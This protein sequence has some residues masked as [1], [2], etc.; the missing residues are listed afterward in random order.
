MA[1]IYLKSGE[2]VLR[3]NKKDER[4]RLKGCPSTPT[5]TSDK[6][7]YQ[8][9]TNRSTIEWIYSNFNRAEISPRVDDF[10]RA[11]MTAEIPDTPFPTDYE[12]NIIPPFNGPMENQRRVLDRAWMKDSFAIFHEMGCGKSLSAISL[13]AAYWMHGETQGALIVCPTAIKFNWVRQLEIHWPSNEYVDWYVLYPHNMRTCEEWIKEDTDACKILIAGVEALSQGNAWKMAEKFLNSTDSMMIIDESSRIKTPY[14]ID[15]KKGIVKKGIRTYRC[16]ELGKLAKRRIIM[17]G[18]QVTQ[19]IEDLYSQFE[20]LD[21]AI[22][23]SSNF[24]AFRNAY[25]VMGGAMGKQ[26][27]GYRDTQK[28][29]Q[30]LAPYT[31][32]CRLDEIADIPEAVQNELIVRL[33]DEQNSL[34]RQLKDELMAEFQGRT[35]TINTI[36]EYMLRAQ[37]VVGGFMPLKKE[38]AHLLRK[39]ESKYESLPLSTNPKLDAA[40]E[41]VQELPPGGKAIIWARFIPEIKRIKRSLDDQ[42]V[43]CVTFYGETAEEDRKRNVEKFED[44]SSGVRIFLGNPA[45][46]GIGIDLIQGRHVL[47]YSNSFSL[48]T[49]LQSMARSRRLGQTEVVTYTDLMSPARIDRSIAA[50][51][52]KKISVSDYARTMLSNPEDLI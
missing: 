5:R 46:G 14:L 48:E 7:I 40:L 34:I 44:T 2:V 51:I 27:V 38:D 36:L 31:D 22:I 6:E 13:V 35:L 41:W 17:T 12:F 28:L 33:T 32:V 24:F 30:L 9:E 19:G 10:M 18:T 52:A 43:S 15:K 8:L 1:I 49:R 20:F 47:Y 21:P 39:S 26:I 3:L 25:C 45:T 23:G 4:W 50:S 11:R 29:F 16:V 42:G 37:Q